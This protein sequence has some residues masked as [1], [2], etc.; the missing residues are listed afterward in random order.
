MKCLIADT[1]LDALKK[2]VDQ[3]IGNETFLLVGNSYGGYLALGMVFDPSMNI[4]GVFLIG[5]C[6]ISDNTKRKLPT[7]GE[8]TINPNLKSIIKS[9]TDFNDFIEVSL[10]PTIKIWHRYEAEILSGLRVADADFLKKYRKRGYGFSFESKLKELAF[11]KPVCILADKQDDVVG[12]EDAWDL[13]KQL[14]R[15]TFV[16][17]DHVGHNLQI[18]NPTVFNV[19]LH[20]WLGKTE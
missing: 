11:M 5:P 6:V 12:Y 16:V 14:P 10:V 13:L 3:V 19:H 8:V 17:I 1:M 18:E 7:K 4:D 20:D 2:F 9:E 15:L